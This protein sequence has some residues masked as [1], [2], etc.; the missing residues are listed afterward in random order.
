LRKE[1]EDVATYEEWGSIRA[2]REGWITYL[3][4]WAAYLA[5]AMAAVLVLLTPVGAR[6]A[7]A[8][9]AVVGEVIASN[10]TYWGGPLIYAAHLF[11]VGYVRL[12]WPF[13]LAAVPAGLVLGYLRRRFGFRYRHIPWHP[14]EA[15]VRLPWP[16]HGMILYASGPL[17]L[18]AM[19]LYV[20]RRV[21]VRL[22]AGHFMFWAT[23]GV[24]AKILWEAFTDLILIVGAKSGLWPEPQRK[25]DAEYQ[26]RRLLDGYAELS[27]MR[28]RDI[29]VD[30]AGR[31]VVTG[32]M[33]PAQKRRLQ[34]LLEHHLAGIVS[35]E[36]IAV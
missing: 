9:I 29:N 1:D 16:L 25:L 26:I 2:W 14:Y 13:L 18:Y 28:V 6:Y 30:R 11:S 17:L 33:T 19:A 34:E 4:S 5:A 22:L 10:F 31:A 15:R 8:V 32:V 12:I 23:S 35:L 20:D 24:L 3:P 7:V 36:I 27:T 21:Y